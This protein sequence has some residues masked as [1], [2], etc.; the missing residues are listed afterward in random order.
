MKVC[1]N[2][3]RRGTRINSPVTLWISLK[4]SSS[5]TTAHHFWRLFFNNPVAWIWLSYVGRAVGIIMT[6]KVSRWC[7]I[8][9]YSKL[10]EE[11]A[12]Y[13]WNG[14]AYRKKTRDFLSRPLVYYICGRWRKLPNHHGTAWKEWNWL[15]LMTIP[16]LHR[17]QMQREGMGICSLIFL[18]FGPHDSFWFC[19]FSSTWA[20][21]LSDHDRSGSRGSAYW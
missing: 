14:Q 3:E 20:A 16:H 21:F 4:H 11:F 6:E 12:S 7:H 18:S 10:W 17:G 13:C 5:G 2:F 9:G 8:S 15:G 1:P 19:A